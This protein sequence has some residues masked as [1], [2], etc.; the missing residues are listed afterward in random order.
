MQPI[1][2]IRKGKLGTITSQLRKWHFF[3]LLVLLAVIY[4][5]SSISA[6]VRP[7]GTRASSEFGLD[8]NLL[9]QWPLG[10]G[11]A[12]SQGLIINTMII[13][14]QFDVED[15]VINDVSVKRCASGNYMFVFQIPYA[16]DDLAI[17]FNNLQGFDG[18]DTS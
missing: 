14:P 18:A 10:Y 12:G 6:A 11:Q 9:T 7:V 8:N 13:C 17:T 15:V 16:P 1:R 4:S 5:P 2:A 3:A